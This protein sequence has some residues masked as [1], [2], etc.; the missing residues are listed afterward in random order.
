MKIIAALV[1]AIGVLA[2]L[3]AHA[4]EMQ[5][6]AAIRAEVAAAFSGE[7]FARLDAM[8]DE[9]R[10]SKSRT[11]SGLW[12]LTLFYAG[13]GDAFD[14]EG[15]SDERWTAVEHRIEQWAK[16]RPDSPTAH[17]AYGMALIGHAWFLRDDHAADA[18]PPEAWASFRRYI[19]RAH[20]YLL[21][22][23]AEASVDP[24]WYET[25]L[26]VARNQ[27]WDA[28]SFRHLLDEAL[29]AEPGFY[30]TYFAAL[31][32]L[33]CKCRGDVTVVE[34]LADDAVTATRQT[35]GTA[36]Y[37]RIYWYASQAQFGND[38]FSDSLVAWPK[39]RASF[40]D[41]IKQYPDAW[42]T[43]NY[44]RFA[45]LAGDRDKARQLF[46]LIG[47][48]PVAEPGSRGRSSPAAAPGR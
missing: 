27:D 37:A 16:R 6:R 8:A 30:Q 33:R 45:C 46:A 9:F 3:P 39:M 47:T 15:A 19:G 11:S 1:L 38:I 21:A 34:A 40:D 35:E 43:N 42:N 4:S 23:K 44:A 7:D 41:I 17:V 22:H 5:D 31:D 29:R 32:Y 10:R 20:D 25:M 12:H 28:R 2:C 36:M 24:R 13:L 14:S 18:V 48:S 26:I